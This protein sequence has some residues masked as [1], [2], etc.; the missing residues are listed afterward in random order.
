MKVTT[1]LSKKQLEAFKILQDSVTT[2]LFYGGGAGGGKS[3]L[4]CFWLIKNCLAYPGSRWLM[5]R[6]RLKT[7]KESTFLTFLGILK[8]WGLKK[9]KDWRYNAMENHINFSNGSAVYLKD[10]FLYPT[11]PEFDSLGSTEFSGAFIDEV[12]E[13][14]EKAKN[15]V[16]SRLRF[17]LTEFGLIPKLLM[18][19]NPAKNFAYR[20]YWKPW[21]E[22]NL[23]KYRQ[24]VPALV[25]D[26][27]FMPEVYAE[28]LQKMDKNSRERLLHGN[29]H[30]D[31]DPSRLFEYEKLQDL[32]TNN[33]VG[34]SRER[35]ISVDVARFGADKTVIMVWKDIIIE[36]I[37]LADKSST[38]QVREKIEYFASIYGVPRSNIVI[39]ED[40]VGG[41]V[42]DEM[43]GVVGF[44][45]NSRP[46]EMPTPKGQLVKHNYAN[47]KTQCYFKLADMVNEGNIAINP[48]R[49]DI[50]QRIIED[51]EQIKVKD[52]EKDNKLTVIP[53]DEIIE[54][55]GRSPDM[56]DALMM[57]MVFFFKRY[58]PLLG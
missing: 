41:G 52:H 51:L 57:R 12:S 23:P 26:N 39:D 36:E 46:I 38:K 54:N 18:A 42:V 45:N 20:E 8:D 33:P 21:N 35:Y 13:I 32:F 53:K 19:S 24:F 15:I 49:D 47:L 27:P 44:V 17:K 29:W 56:A 22:G 2:E 3:Y 40:G 6:A 28:N 37:Y 7:L 34:T 48:I 16:M 55:L 58:K 10:L 1:E 5:G 31:D 50:K 30:Y 14:T 4:G 25:E 9:D 43:Q 11:D